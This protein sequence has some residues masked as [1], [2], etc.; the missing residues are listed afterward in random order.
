MP[1]AAAPRPSEGNGDGGDNPGGGKEEAKQGE[2]QQA[3]TS[4]YGIED[5]INRILQQMEV[6]NRDT[7]KKQHF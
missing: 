2:A 3:A 5:L 7:Q 6:P 4:A 1:V